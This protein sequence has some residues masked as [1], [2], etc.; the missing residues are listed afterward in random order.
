MISSPVKWIGGKAA[1][2]QRIVA[3]FPQPGSYDV[4]IEPCG[5]A[6]HVL[7]NKPPYQHDEILNDRD[8][9]L[10]N[11]WRMLQSHASELRDQ[12]LMRPYAR[13][14]YYEYHHSLFG[15][16]TQPPDSSLDALEKAVRWFYVL[17]SNMTGYLRQST[18]GWTTQHVKTMKQVAD[19]LFLAVQER[20][21]YVAID[22]RD[23]I[24]TI[25]RYQKLSKRVFFYVDPP[26][27][28]VEHYYPACRE[29]QG[30]FNHEALATVL[31]AC[32]RP[33]ALSYYPH[34]RIDALYPADKWHR[35]TWQQYKPSSCAQDGDSDTAT[36]ML[37]CNYAPAQL[38]AVQATLFHTDGPLLPTQERMCL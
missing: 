9:L 38:A 30:G 19:Q 10:I 5:G 26:Y 27:F 33:V 15:T 37:L 35:I 31:N 3:A 17:R 16:R 7:L 8:G 21:Q 34:P 11:F 13:E 12:V 2:A 6:A 22:N 24:A 20:I 32:P 23:V 28:G 25:L 4:Y 29:Q 36:E 1:A 14:L 18:P